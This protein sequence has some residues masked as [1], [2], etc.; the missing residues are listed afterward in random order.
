MTQDPARHLPLSPLTFHLLLALTEGA[1]HGYAIGKIIE[2]RT[3]GRLNPTTGSLYQALK[4]LS[5]AGW[6]ESVATV[7]GESTDSRR[8]YFTLTDLGWRVARAEARRY[9]NLVDL[10]HQSKLLGE[11]S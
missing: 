5:D 10:A 8:Q 11:L 9:Q 6:I 7:E 4:R 1:S 2:N 3:E